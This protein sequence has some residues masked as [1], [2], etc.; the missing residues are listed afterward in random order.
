M[1]AFLMAA[2]TGL[3][4]VVRY[5]VLLWNGTDNA[6]GTDDKGK[7]VLQLTLQAGGPQKNGVQWLEKHCRGL[8]G[9]KLKMTNGGSTRKYDEKQS[10]QSSRLYRVNTT[11]DQGKGTGK[12]YGGGH[13]GGHQPTFPYNGSINWW[14]GPWLEEGTTDSYGEDLHHRGQGSWHWE[15]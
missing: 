12:T 1:S 15:Q 14:S 10:G 2:S 5:L 6:F 3:Q 13:D 4:D 11:M 7:G 9:K 8:N